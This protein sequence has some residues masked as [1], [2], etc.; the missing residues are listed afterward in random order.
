[1]AHFVSTKNMPWFGMFKCIDSTTEQHMIV[2]LK[3]PTTY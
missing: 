1:M 3:L 2:T